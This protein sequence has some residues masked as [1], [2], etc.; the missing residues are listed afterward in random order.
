MSTNTR[1][2]ECL[3]DSWISSVICTRDSV[4]REELAIFIRYLWHYEPAVNVCSMQVISLGVKF[5]HALVFMQQQGLGTGRWSEPIHRSGWSSAYA[6]SG[7][8]NRRTDAPLNHH[9]RLP[10]AHIPS[11]RQIY[12]VK[13]FWNRRAH[14]GT[15][16]LTR[17]SCFFMWQG[18]LTLF[19]KG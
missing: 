18:K 5:K 11:T 16:L 4:G 13:I 1:A 15:Q 10:V 7:Y 6:S 3:S 17:R 2:C 9:R 14:I 8:L 19:F 12:D